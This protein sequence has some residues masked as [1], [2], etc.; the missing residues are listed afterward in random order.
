MT[1]STLRCR[2][3][4]AYDIG[5]LLQAGKIQ[6]ILQT[7]KNISVEDRVSFNKPPCHCPDRSLNDGIQLRR[8]EGFL[9]TH[10]HRR[11]FGKTFCVV[12]VLS[13]PIITLVVD[14]FRDGFRTVKIYGIGPSWGVK[15]APR[16]VAPSVVVRTVV[17]EFTTSR[18]DLV[19]WFLVNGSFKCIPA[20]LAPFAW[21]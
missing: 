3:A 11:L 6:V 14:I 9:P 7:V 20:S 5:V 15:W 4:S 2:E 1:G 12:V 18:T 19:V 13:V 17:A 16:R 21:F 8:S 10:H